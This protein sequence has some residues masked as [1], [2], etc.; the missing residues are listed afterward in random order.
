MGTLEAFLGATLAGLG[1]LLMA[2]ALMARR[3]ADSRRFGVIAAA[4]GAA[5]LGGAA[6]AAGEFL[7]GATAEGARVLFPAAVLAAMVLWY[8]ALFAGKGR[9]Q[10]GR[11]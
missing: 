6:L 10:E 1:G 7:G 5:A 4:F 2:V 8:T 9:P 11:R 3:R